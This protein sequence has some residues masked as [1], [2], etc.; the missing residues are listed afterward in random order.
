ME[1]SGPDHPQLTIVDLPGLIHSPTKQQSSSDIDLIGNLVK[2][3]MKETR[4]II[5]AVVSAKYDY[6]NQIALKLARDADPEGLRTIGVITEPDKLKKNSMGEDSFIA[7]A[8]NEDVKF[9]HGWHVLRNLDT[10]DS[11]ASLAVRHAEE[12]KVLF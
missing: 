12:Q 3:K 9:H 10:E 7:L 2:D 4:S 8:E 6:A 5:L 1:V 11:S